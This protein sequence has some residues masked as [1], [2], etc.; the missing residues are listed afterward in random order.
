VFCSNRGQ[1]GGCGKTFS[2]VLADILPR[3]TLTSSLVW[4]WL[5]E[6]LAGLSI[7]AAAE[8]LRLP[9]VLET[10]YRLRRG[11]R[12]CLDLVRTQLCREQPPPA[13]TNTDPLLQTVEHLR[14]VFPDSECPPAAFQLHFQCPFLG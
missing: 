3:H 9:F 13:S 5:V 11:L 7:K 14:L 1:R 6:V 10:I 8:K 12:R 2:L 4:R